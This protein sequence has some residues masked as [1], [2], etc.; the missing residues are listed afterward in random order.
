M[1]VHAAA[2]V[3]LAGLS[4]FCGLLDRSGDGPSD[5]EEGP[6]LDRFVA[7]HVVERRQYGRVKKVA[8]IGSA[9]TALAFVRFSFQMLIAGRPP[10]VAGVTGHSWQ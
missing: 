10:P 7:V 9:A 5:S 6:L 2:R 1:S 8:A 3:W 4:D